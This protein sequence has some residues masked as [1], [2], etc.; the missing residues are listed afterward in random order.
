MRVDISSL[1]PVIRGG[2]SKPGESNLAGFMGNAARASRRDSVSIS[3]QGKE[4]MATGNDF[5]QSLMDQK[6]ALKQRRKDLTVRL[7]TEPNTDFIQTQIKEVDKSLQAIDQQMNE[8]ML[9]KQQEALEEQKGKSGQ[10]DKDL[11]KEEAEAKQMENIT[12]A[13][14]RLSTMDDLRRTRKE[15]VRS[16]LYVEDSAN[17]NYSV[18]SEANQVSQEA[19]SAVLEKFDA[20]IHNLESTEK[21]LMRQAEELTEKAA[22][23]AASADS[24]PEAEEAAVENAGT[25]TPADVQSQKKAEEE[26]ARQE[27]PETEGTE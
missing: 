25:E 9:Q 19:N 17:S 10:S 11:T 21:G 8:Y 27:E 14:D 2:F 7:A 24:T 23:A 26:K 22:E 4:R 16:R 6:D 15:M 1:N 20:G 5:L 3:K 13:S 12:A 18:S